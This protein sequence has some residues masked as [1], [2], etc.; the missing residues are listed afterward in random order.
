MY[1]AGIPHKEISANLKVNIIQARRWAVQ[2]G[3]SQRRQPGVPAAARRRIL[4]LYGLGLGGIKICKETGIDESGVY[5]T[6]RKAGIIRTK[7]QAADIL[8]DLRPL[9]MLPL[10]AERAWVL[11]VIFGDGGITAARGGR[12]TLTVSAE[13]RDGDILDKIATI[14]NVKAAIYQRQGCRCLYV[15]GKRFV[16]Q[17][18]SEFGLDE[19]KCLNM[20]W[21]ELPV[22]LRRHFV[23]GLLDSDGCWHRRK[24]V[25]G[26]QL[27]FSYASIAE[28]FVRSLEWCVYG[29]VDVCPRAVRKISRKRAV[30]AGG[31]I[32]HP[33]YHLE[34][35]HMDCVEIG[36]W[37]YRGDTG[38]MRG[39]RKYKYWLEHSD[40]FIKPHWVLRHLRHRANAR[41]LR[42][43]SSPSGSA[44]SGNRRAQT[45][46]A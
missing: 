34:Y 36:K 46:R 24:T 35:S 14:L 28:S 16:D 29:H 41:L 43:S 44:P 7:Q 39:E 42:S 10:T 20:V 45:Q 3:I 11:G 17:L 13:N 8:S 15:S 26:N 9:R 33:S 1:V 30:R 27:V 25:C 21:P 18:R 6:I 22:E 37:L 19:N 38:H 4:E 23:R 31:A 40:A 32:P 5:R 2:R 12:H